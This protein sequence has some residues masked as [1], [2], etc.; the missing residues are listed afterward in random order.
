[1]LLGDFCD[2][3]NL[4]DNNSIDVIWVG[5]SLHHLETADKAAF[6]KTVHNA[7]AQEDGLLLIYEPICLP[8]QSRQD[9]YE[10]FQRVGRELWSDIFN[11]SEFE[12]LFEHVTQQDIPEP[13]QDWLT[14]GKDIESHI[15]EGFDAIVC[16]GNSFAHLP[17]CLHH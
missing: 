9:Y 7:L 1:M 5:L 16:M 17:A 14:L 10:R 13:N 8:G 15:E 11:P 2:Y 4:N 12:Q 6:L 3:P